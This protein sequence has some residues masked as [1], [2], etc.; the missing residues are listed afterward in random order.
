MK[1]NWSVYFWAIESLSFSDFLQRMAWRMWEIG[2]SYGD[3]VVSISCHR[4]SRI[5]IISVQCGWMHWTIVNMIIL[6]F[7]TAQLMC[8]CI[9]YNRTYGHTITEQYTCGLSFEPFFYF[10]RCFLVLFSHF[11][12]HSHKRK[13]VFGPISVQ[14]NMK[15]K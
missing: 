13:I 10:F 5:V 12:Q 11:F 3:T 1:F 2:V 15:L 6:I 9:V 4:N 8:Q 14:C 7:S